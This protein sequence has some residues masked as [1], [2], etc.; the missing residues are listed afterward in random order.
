MSLNASQQHRLIVTCQYV[1]RLLGDLE[2]VFIEADANS[3]FGRYT[4]DL[5][6]AEKRLV[7]D[8]IARLRTQLARM[9]DTQGLSPTPQR[10][11]LRHSLLTLLTFVDI[12]VEELKPHYMRGYGA[13]APE[14]AAALNGIAEELH[15]TIG[16]LTRALAVDRS[17]DLRTRLAQVGVGA[18]A[19]LLETL[20]E[21][22]TK[23]GLVECRS[24]L[25]TILDTLERRGLE[26]AVFGRVS[27][28]KSSLLN[29]LLERDVLPVGVTPITAVPTRIAFG[30][31]PR[32][33]VRF[34]DRP[35]RELDIASLP[36]FAS[37]RDN[38]ANIRRVMRLVVELP[39]PF[40]QSGVTLVDT[41][42][43][44]SLATAGADETLA[45]LPHCDVAAVLVDAGS[46]IT[47]DDL[48]TVGLLL[49]AGIRVSVLVSKADLLAEGDREAAVAYTGRILSREFGAPLPVAAVSVKPGY[50]H[51]F[52][53]WRRS[54]LDP[55]VADQERER[56]RAAAAKAEVLRAQ[57]AAGLRQRLEAH[58]ASAPDPPRDRSRATD[59]ILQSA[60]GRVTDLEQQLDAVTLAL[61]RRV[62]EVLARAADLI[63]AGAASRTALE[64]AF[65]EIAGEAAR[66]VGRDLQALA[67]WLAET[68][69]QLVRSGDSGWAP[70]AALERAAAVREVPVP[71]LPPDLVVPGEG[72]E[73][74]LGRGLAQSMLARR[75]DRAVGDAVRSALDGYGAV[76]RRWALDVLG[77]VRVQ[78]SATTDALRAD[79]DRQ[80]GHGRDRPVDPDELRRDLNRLALSAIR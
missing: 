79:L 73:R 34:A 72:A 56:Q 76:L 5:A 47:A 49:K 59:L 7:H 35:S 17:G 38:P 32:L 41:P 29:R 80:L 57:V 15:G 36:R 22:V 66:D 40:L 61:P 19:E 6:P 46:T 78:W 21:L 54:E 18:D 33:R 75:L 68:H 9:L 60:A 28:G 1:D 12:A 13:V 51:L 52:E 65:R 67:T 11:G 26:L 64:Q 63:A 53:R 45:Y 37:E 25:G 23:Y 71:G 39:S 31:A 8:Y 50:E 27:T 58:D 69:R 70:A 74:V 2:R 43:L 30:P 4:S 10:V 20:E 55:L 16:Q 14:A 48:A 62:P 3:P 44:G 77:E 24:A 42:G